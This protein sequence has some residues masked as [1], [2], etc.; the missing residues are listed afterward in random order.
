MRQS[1]TASERRTDAY[2]RLG[3]EPNA[4]AASSHVTHLL[5]RLEG[6]E[7]R[8][9]EY[10]RGSDTSEARKFISVFDDLTLSRSARDL[11]PFEAFC[12]A[13]GLSPVRM[14]EVIVGAAITQGAQVG[15][16]IAAAAHPDIVQLSVDMAKLP[17]GEKDR[18][19]QLKHAGFLPQPKGNT[20]NVHAT[21][22]SLTQNQSA[23]LAI[24]PPP[25]D[26]IRRM[27]DRFNESR[28]TGL[29]AMDTPALPAASDIQSL[30]DL[31]FPATSASAAPVAVPTQPS[32]SPVEADYMDD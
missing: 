28:R 22:N 31:R 26:T 29:P 21:A 18:E 6:G 23:T 15:A 4:V 12:L 5:R 3:V 13:A 20:I 16:L 11:L 17:T 7:R 19:F 10:L 32:T 27:T 25:E 14:V 24:A 9:I 2:A 8:A 1:R 30:D